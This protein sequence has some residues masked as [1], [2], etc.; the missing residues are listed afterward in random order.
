MSIYYEDRKIVTVIGS[1]KFRKEITEWAL[2]HT[3]LHFLVLFAP[4]AKEEI[5]NLESIR[6]E[7]EAQHFQ[8][9]RMADEIMVYNK[10]GYLGTS[11][12]MELEYAKKLGK[13]ITYYEECDAF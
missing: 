10:D 1:T 7:L 2:N 4:F 6:D 11:S 13:K 9:I 5:P 3:R 12:V 8:K